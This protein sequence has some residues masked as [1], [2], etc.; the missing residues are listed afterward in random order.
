MP[1]SSL[2]KVDP[3]DL[4]IKFAGGEAEIRANSAMMTGNSPSKITLGGK[5]P[6]Q[7]TIKD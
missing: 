3:N 4:K 6:N 1:K 2:G 5:M 7:Q